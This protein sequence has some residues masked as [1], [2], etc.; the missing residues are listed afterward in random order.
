METIRAGSQIRVEDPLID[1]I[2]AIVRRTRDWPGLHLGAS[3][4]AG[5]A[6]VQGSRTLAAFLGRDYAIPDDVVELALPVLRH[7][8]ILTAEAEVEGRTV[9]GV[10][11]DLIR[12]IEVPRI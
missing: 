8:V 12:S 5:L 10:L 4:R 9:D 6:L 7:R 3:P 2:N 1:Y 11:S